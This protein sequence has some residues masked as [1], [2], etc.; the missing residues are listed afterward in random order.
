MMRSLPLAALALCCLAAP[1][2]AVDSGLEVKVY[3]VSASGREVLLYPGG[4]FMRVVPA[5]R[6]PGDT[7]APVRLHMPTRRARIASAAPAQAPV[8]RPRPAPVERPRP[9]PKVAAAPPA[10]K[11]ASAAPAPTAPYGA[12]PGAAGLF[13]NLP[14]ISA[15]PQPNAQTASAAPPASAPSSGNEAMAKQGV[16]L[17]AHDADSPADSALDSI[18]LLAG[19]LNNGMTRTQSRVELMAYGGNKG[20]KGSDARRLSLKRAL[21]IRQV[22][23]DAG[24]SSARI[25]VHAQGG[26]DDTGPTDRVDVFI[27]A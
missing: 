16:I 22:L 18:R 11:V 25:D 4:Q 14:T 19:Q 13:G 9:A 23:I 5:L 2:L 26:V 3:P 6:Q 1:A 17:F 27:R 12:G 20:D 8:E 24:V 21:A 15:T 10:P 7:G